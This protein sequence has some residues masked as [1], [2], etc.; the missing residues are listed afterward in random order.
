MVI[1][2]PVF[3]GNAKA[4]DI[5]T[6]ATTSLNLTDPDSMTIDPRGNIVLDSQADSELIFIR[7]PMPLLPASAVPAG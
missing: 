3:N 6:G 5:P 2:Q 1:L 4:T 7:H